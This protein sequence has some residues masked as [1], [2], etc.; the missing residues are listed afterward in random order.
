MRLDLPVAKIAIA[1]GS[2]RQSVYNW[3]KGGEVFVA[4][5]PIVEAIITTMRTSSTAEE[6]WRKLC[7][8]FD[9]RT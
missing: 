8:Q 1:V 2:T 3:M 5:R 6:S 9:L 4:Y 7:R